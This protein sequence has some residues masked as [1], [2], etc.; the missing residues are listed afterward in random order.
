MLQVGSK[1]AC[2][3]A[4]K[5]PELKLLKCGNGPDCPRGQDGGCH[6][7]C[8]ATSAVYM[9]LPKKQRD[10]VLTR[11]CEVCMANG[12]QALLEKN[13]QVCH[14]CH[15]QLFDGLTRKCTVCDN[16]VH[17]RCLI[18]KNEKGVCKGCKS[19]AGK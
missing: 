17:Y 15:L 19:T 2:S 14:Y 4:C 18:V 11:M 7:V 10:E 5:H 6:H 16:I 3:A 1:G 9:S 13:N 12:V 8:N